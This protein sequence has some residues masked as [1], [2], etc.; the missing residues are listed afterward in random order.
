MVVSDWT[1]I[2]FPYKAKEELIVRIQALIKHHVLQGT[3][4][5]V[6]GTKAGL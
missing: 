3:L 2:L 6:F 4:G 1:R 5:D